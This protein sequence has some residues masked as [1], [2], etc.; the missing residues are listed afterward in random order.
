MKRPWQIA[1]VFAVALAVV[2]A[3]MGWISSEVLRLDRD[4]AET[5]RLALQEENVRLALWRMESALALLIAQ[6]SAR[7]PAD[8]T[9]FRPVDANDAQRPVFARSAPQMPSP[10]L[11]QTSPYV[12]LHFQIDAAGRLTSPQ[13]PSL[14]DAPQ[15]QAP[16]RQVSAKTGAAAESRLERLRAI[17]SRDVLETALA[18]GTEPMSSMAAVAMTEPQQEVQDGPQE[19]QQAKR[20]QPQAP[21]SG[22]QGQAQPPPQQTV[23]QAWRNVKEWQAR[24]QQMDALS[25]DINLQ[26]A[27]NLDPSGAGG[28]TVMRPLWIGDELFLV[29]WA[30][31]EGADHLQGV[32]LDWPAIRAWLLDGVLDLVPLADLVPVTGD[33]DED[34]TRRLAAVPVRIIPGKV[35]VR[36]ADGL[37]PVALSLLVAWVCVL[38]GAAA[39]GLLLTGAVRLSERR[40]DFVSAVTHELRTPLTTFRMYSEMLAEGMVPDEARRRQYLTTLRAEAERLTHMVENVLAYA[41]LERGRGTGE[42]ERLTLAELMDRVRDR[43]E[44]RTR[45]AG[46]DLVIDVGDEADAATV[47]VRVSAVEQILYNL[48]DNACKYAASASDRRIHLTAAPADGEAVL[49]VRDYGPGIS[50]AEARR[51]F[52]PFS[53]SARQAAVSAPGVG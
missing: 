27:G 22:A 25:R 46:M 8:Y 40:G 37:S 18:A 49:T 52:R 11:V 2:L 42:A 38:G 28:V 36:E 17:V 14:T 21:N 16:P 3:A 41:R 15:D 26:I 33:P 44:R 50:R 51:L 47:W 6:E 23:A 34:R 45:G 9:A 39:V 1:L 30:R 53:K 31:I 48:V 29:R 12:R 4:Q 24:R 7:P 5:K 32:W 35:P 19:P 10:V 13:V 43:I 20:P